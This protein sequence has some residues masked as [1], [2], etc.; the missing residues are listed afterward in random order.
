M[1]NWLQNLGQGLGGI[2]NALQPFADYQ[3]AQQ[4]EANMYKLAAN[5]QFAQAV[6]SQKQANEES[7]LKR[8]ALQQKMMEIASG[9]NSPAAVQEYQYWSQLSPDEQKKYLT[10]KRAQQIFSTGGAQNVLDPSGQG[11][12][13]Q[14]P[15]T[16]PPE[17]MPEFKGA[18][19]AA[20]A[21]GKASGQNAA[22]VKNASVVLSAFDE[23]GSVTNAPSGTMENITASAANAFPSLGSLVGAENIAKGQGEFSVKRAAAENQARAAFRIAG[24]GAQSDADAKPIIDMLPN[25]TDS[26]P[27]KIAKIKAAKEALVTQANAKALANGLEPPF[28]ENIIPPVMP[29]AVGLTNLPDAGGI[30]GDMGLPVTGINPSAQGQLQQNLS[31]VPEGAVFIGTK[32]GKKVYRLPDG[33]GWME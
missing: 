14:F 12:S 33:R 11:I 23:L 4:N 20:A 25:V 24:S 2:V 8:L 26:Q 30:S 15:M 9:G 27:V 19:A 18:Q 32:G 16:P 22:N 17:Q 29:Q 6:T 5:P 21:S 3:T 10:V 7:A 1:A 31:G 13:Q 28:P